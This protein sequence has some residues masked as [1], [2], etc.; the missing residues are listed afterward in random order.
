MPLFLFI[1]II[2]NYSYSFL[3]DEVFL[4][5][6]LLFTVSIVSFCKAIYF[7]QIRERNITAF[8]TSICL[9]KWMKM[10]KYI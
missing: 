1:I 4:H 2:I 5:K 3:G 9:I 6:S 8:A 10:C 7:V